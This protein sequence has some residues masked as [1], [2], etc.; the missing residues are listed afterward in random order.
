MKK[1]TDTTDRVMENIV[2]KKTTAKDSKDG[3]D[4]KLISNKKVAFTLVYKSRKRG[5]NAYID[6]GEI[7]LINLNGSGDEKLVNGFCPS[8]SP[9]GKEIAYLN[10]VVDAPSGE[11]FKKVSIINLK[12][13]KIR[14]IFE[15]H[16]IYF[17]I[18]WLNDGKLLVVAQI[19]EKDLSAA[20]V[21]TRLGT[22][23]TKY[24]YYPMWSPDGK[25]IL[26]ED[27]GNGIDIFATSAKEGSK[28]IKNLTN[29]KGDEFPTSISKEG[30]LIFISEQSRGKR[31]NIMNYNGTNMEILFNIRDEDTGPRWFPDSK[32]FLY[33]IHYNTLND[34]RS[35][36]AIFNIETM[37]EQIL[38]KDTYTY[39]INNWDISPDGK[40]IVYQEN[41]YRIYV[42]YTNGA[43]YLL[44]KNIDLSIL[45][46]DESSKEKGYIKVDFYEDGYRSAYTPS[47]SI[48]PK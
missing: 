14:N 35:K 40:F 20:Y 34:Q 44:T 47:L 16:R 43:K 13:R 45:A 36:L 9:N 5:G 48:Q 6:H 23:V 3:K 17:T 32:R 30:R 4:Q 33:Q 37:E 39:S 11:Y 2:D 18:K 12:T 31:I 29:L 8:W 46:R 26:F 22:I 10:D 24:P 27:K 21:I 7:H 41:G 28:T 25:T 42:I 1:M 19:N 38:L 15:G